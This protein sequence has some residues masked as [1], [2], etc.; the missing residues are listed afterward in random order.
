LVVCWIDREA[1]TVRLIFRRLAAFDL[2]GVIDNES[3]T[4]KAQEVNRGPALRRQAE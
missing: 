3:L 1:E 4:V 2:S